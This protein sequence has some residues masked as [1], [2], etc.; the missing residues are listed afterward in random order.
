MIETTDLNTIITAL[1][2][3]ILAIIAWYNKQRTATAATIA[4]ATT[5]TAISNAVIEANERPKVAATGFIMPRDG[6]YI[7]AGLDG[8]NVRLN[9]SPEAAT[10][11][12]DK[13]YQA[14]SPRGALWSGDK[15]TVMYLVSSPDA[16]GWRARFA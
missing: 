12:D 10:L 7:A 3:L 8:W 1:M 15:D 11:P 2:A 6:K 16:A 13:A 5:Q 9:P 4:T 14:V